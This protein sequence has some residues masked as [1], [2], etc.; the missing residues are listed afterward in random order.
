MQRLLDFEGALVR[1]EPVTVGQEM[2]HGETLQ[3]YSRFLELRRRRTQSVG[4]TG[5]P[6]VVWVVLLAGAVLNVALTFL[7][8]VRT[9]AV[10]LLLTCGLAGS[11][12]LLIFLIAAMDR[13]Y[14]G[15]YSVG[16]G[17]FEALRLQMLER[18]GADP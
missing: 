2:L 1:F 11:V 10:H 12:G 5:L 13:P 15:E 3:A 8:S 17:P 6:P 7:F 18:S 16:P 4:N 14:R 9:V